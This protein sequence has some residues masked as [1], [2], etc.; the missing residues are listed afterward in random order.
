MH[1]YTLTLKRPNFRGTFDFHTFVHLNTRP[2]V[3]DY[4]VQNL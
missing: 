1:R 4:T 2:N 3:V